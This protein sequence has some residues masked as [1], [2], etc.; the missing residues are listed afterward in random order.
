MNK[1]QLRIALIS[2]SP[3][4]TTGFGTTSRIIAD[5]LYDAG[6]DVHCFGLGLGNTP[7]T[8]LKLPYSIWATGS[9]GLESRLL[10]HFFQVANPEIVIL[11]ADIAAVNSWIPKVVAAGY[12]GPLVGHIVVDGLP[13]YS[14]IHSN[15]DNLG[16]IMAP[17]E[18]TAEYLRSLVRS[19]VWT[20]PHG[21]DRSIFRPIEN[22]DEIRA[23]A[24]LKNEFLVGIFGR[25]VYRK[26]HVR[27]LQAAKLLQG[28]SSSP[29]VHLYFHCQPVDFEGREGWNLLELAKRMQ[30]V[31]SV[32]FPDP[33]F[34]HT[35]GVPYSRTQSNSSPCSPVGDEAK[36]F[37]PV[38][39]SYVERLG[40]CD[41][42][43]NPAIAG[44][45]ELI[46]LEAQ[47][48]GVPIAVTDDKGNMMEV[49][50]AG[51]IKMTPIDTSIWRFG[52]L[53]HFVSPV[54][55][56]AV[57]NGL[58]FDNSVLMTLR[59]AGFDNVK[60]FDWADLREAARNAV[61]LFA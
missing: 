59:A 15:I 37:W 58:R 38:N 8:Q 20:V 50:G 54:E 24:G 2:E 47:S 30:L 36:R 23:E 53:S 10:S 28:D 25:N 5:T 57:I 52:G 18:T 44:G 27:V 48:V 11:N 55:I 31:D 22:R 29:S 13:T 45:F 1:K 9:S 40:S 34:V 43:V 56:A 14:H 42:I 21:V 41:L 7:G 26:Q 6:H 61:A 4:R 60:R 32:T 39:H 17:T 3:A 19:Q 51:G 16:L 33:N 46:I 35:N 12:H 49:M